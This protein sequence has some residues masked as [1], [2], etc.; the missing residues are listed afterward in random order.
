M[1]VS[2]TTL[3]QMNRDAIINSSYRKL[4]VI[5]EG[6]VANA[7]QLTD[8]AEALNGIMAEFQTLGMPLWKRA[9]LSIPIVAG[10]SEYT[11]GTGKAINT[12]YPLKVTQ[13]DLA[14]PGNSTRLNIE[15]IARFNYNNLPTSTSGTPI[16]VTY[17]PFV[18]YGVLSM[19]PTPD[20][21][22][23]AGTAVVITYTAPFFKFDSGTDTADIPQEWYNAVI[24]QL[25]HVLSDEFSLPLDDRGWLEKQAGKRLATA[26]SM[27]DEGTS[28]FFYP[29]RGM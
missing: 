16:Q 5:G 27:A 26:L 17:Q 23:V 18:E 1:T 25:A 22:L 13:A 21:S 20:T 10:Q 24:Y 29:D 14:V 3:W 11:I 9:E 19:W 7:Q 15:I 28:L 6:Q 2:T 12:P 4:S 8:A